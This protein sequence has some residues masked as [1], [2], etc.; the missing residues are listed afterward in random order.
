[1]P[2]FNRMTIVAATEVL[3]DYKSHN[4]IELLQVEWG[5]A[6]RCDASSKSGRAAALA[7]IAI[8]EN[9][10]VI[11]ENGRMTLSDA[12]INLAINA[13]SSSRDKP[14]WRKLVA[15]LRLDGFEISGI[16]QVDPDL[17]SWMS[18]SPETASEPIVL[19]RMLPVD[20]P[21]L[22]MR[23]AEN[24]VDHLL[25]K[26]GFATSSGH[27]KRAISAFQR[28]DWSSSNAELRNLYEGL[29]NDIAAGLGY[30][31]NGD[32][33]AKRNFLGEGV[34]PPFL[35]S[36]YNE[37]NANTQKP[38]YVQGLMSRMHPHGSHPGLSE[39][40]DATFR[41]QI[42]LVTARLFLRRYDQRKG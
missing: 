24:E 42:A 26:H 37:W 6:G 28:G 27:V 16:E 15:G 41:V 38:Q 39:E 1:M 20:L 36:D 23:E 32:S 9:A 5:I 19:R 10:Q 7:N 18:A 21:G 30:V 31:G 33:L 22:D 29:L 35:L 34:T 4:E 25:Q 17:P 14:A 13:P 40:E 11:T 8:E 2:D 3:S 12:L